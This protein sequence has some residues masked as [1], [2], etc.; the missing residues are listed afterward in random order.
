MM[1]PN[2]PLITKAEG[3]ASEFD[4]DDNAIDA[5]IVRALVARL[6]AA[7]AVLAE[8]DVREA[9]RCYSIYLVWRA[10]VD[11]EGTK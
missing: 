9:A 11:G 6:R 2:D 3:L 1:T 8:Y 4:D 10:L 7:E 5:A